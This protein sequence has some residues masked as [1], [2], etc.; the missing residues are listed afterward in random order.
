M[1]HRILYDFCVYGA[2]FIPFWFRACVCVRVCM[3][4]CAHVY[5]LVCV[6]F[7]VCV[8]VCVAR[9]SYRSGRASVL[10]R[11]FI[12][13]WTSGRGCER[14]SDMVFFRRLN[15]GISLQESSTGIATWVRDFVTILAMLHSIRRSGGA[16]LEGTPAQRIRTTT[17]AYAILPL[18]RIQ[19]SL[20]PAP[21]AR[22][23][24]LKELPTPTQG[25][26]S[27]HWAPNHLDEEPELLRCTTQTQIRH[28]EMQK[29]AVVDQRVNP[30]EAGNAVL[31]CNILYSYN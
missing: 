1:Q 2:V 6:G 22:S 7:F 8:C 5:S 11:I 24:Q 20:L 23:E 15:A 17:S 10:A 19:C 29:N 3:W 30:G 25:H 13:I 27:D 12:L 14:M 28:N 4:M 21:L 18:S 16:T 9:S 26:A 31:Q